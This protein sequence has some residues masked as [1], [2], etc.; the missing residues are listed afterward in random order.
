MCSE[1][2]VGHHR[3]GGGDR[4]AGQPERVPGGL[5]GADYAVDHGRYRFA[6]VFGGLNWNPGLRAPLTEPGVDVTAGEYLLA[7]DGVDLRAPDNLFARF[8]NTAGRSVRLT[9]G[10]DPDGADSREVTVV[11]IPDESALRNRDWVEGNVRKV[12]EATGGRVAYVYVPNTTTAGHTYFKRYF[13]PQADKQ[14]IILDERHNG[15]G[16]L[17]DYYL[18]HLRRPLLC[19][20]AMRYGEDLKSPLSSIQGPKVMLIDETAGSGGDFL[21]WAFRQLGLGPLIGRRTWGGLV[22][23]LGFPVLMDGGSVTAPNLAIWTEDGFIVENV[24]VPPD[25]EVEQTPAEV[26]AGRDPQLE[27]AIAEVLRMLDADPPQPAVRP[28]RPIRVRR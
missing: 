26:M 18:D 24:G 13:F 11:P 4:R 15:G 9:V 5:L 6:K 19:H 10:P 23:T 2:A 25:I 22:G 20:W 21:P 28:D 17:A 14:A 1:L 7:V 12:A 3:V 16:Q 27:R 8:E